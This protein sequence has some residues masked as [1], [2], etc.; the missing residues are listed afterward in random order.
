MKVP[1]PKTL[2]DIEFIQNANCLYGAQA[3]GKLND[4]S[5]I[6]DVSTVC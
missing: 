5:G 3:T 2:A 4:N 1:V 6:I